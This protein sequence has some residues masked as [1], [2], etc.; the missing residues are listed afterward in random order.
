MEGDGLGGAIN[1]LA[2]SFL[3]HG[4]FG[5]LRSRGV[6]VPPPGRLLVCVSG[7]L[8]PTRISVHF[9]NLSILSPLFSV[10]GRASSSGLTAFVDKAQSRLRRRGFARCAVESS[11][12]ARLG[13]DL[14]RLLPRGY[15]EPSES[16]LESR[17]VEMLWA[18][19]S[20][21]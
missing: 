15:E 14:W 2:I 19:A 10:E 9:Q 5:S 20:K 16:P 4:H 11:G 3:S 6:P 7:F 17:K 8:P 12:R 18:N 13:W 1:V 21:T